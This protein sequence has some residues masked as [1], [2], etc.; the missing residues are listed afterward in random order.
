MGSCT[1]LIAQSPIS[2]RAF[3]VLYPSSLTISLDMDKAYD[4]QATEDR[5]YEMWENTG[6]F[7]ANN[8]TDK[9]TFTITMPPPKATGQLH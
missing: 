3:F 8:T 9:E 2:N 1:Y 6:A 5:I 7:T 4:P